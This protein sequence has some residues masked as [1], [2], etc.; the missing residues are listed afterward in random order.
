MSA[1]IWF[2]FLFVIFLALFWLFYT[3]AI[4]SEYGPTTAKRAR[5]MIEL[6]DV[7]KKDIVYDLGS[8]FGGLVIM[9]ARQAK[10]AVGIEFD[11][12]RYAF[13]V[14]RAF[15]HG[16]KN[17]KFIRGNL[18]KEYISDANVVLLFLKQKTNQKLKPKLL[19]LR[20]GTRIVSNLWTFEGWKPARQDKKL[21]VYMYVVGKSDKK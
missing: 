15:F 7:K 19:R 11:S 1:Q 3:R 12:L 13:S 14:A 5:R 6:A 2:I 20:K 9:A 4:G 10:E 18:F 8:G 16:A 21:K 17:V